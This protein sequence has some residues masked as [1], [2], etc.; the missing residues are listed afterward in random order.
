MLAL[1][2]G[3]ITGVAHNLYGEP[4][5]ESWPLATD[6]EV[7]I[8][9]KARLTRRCD[10]RIFRLWN[11]LLSLS[12]KP[13]LVLFEDIQFSSTTYQCQL[14]SSF[15]TTVWLAFGLGTVF[16][17]VPVGTLKKF[18][19][20]HGGATKPMMEAALRKT[21]R[22]AVDNLDDNAVDAAWLFEWAIQKIRL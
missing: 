11:K 2:L 20:G 13:D 14:W 15:R 16:D 7:N 22:W 3:T 12:G 18:A 1:D 17:C 5:A 9:G 8:W 4:R 10:P 21:G 19:T 6:K